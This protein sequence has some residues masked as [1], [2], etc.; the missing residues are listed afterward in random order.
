MPNNGG[1]AT[2]A[3]IAA[4]IIYVAYALSIR[5]RSRALCERLRAAALRASGKQ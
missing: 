3:Y 4:A 5:V 1:Y 2:A